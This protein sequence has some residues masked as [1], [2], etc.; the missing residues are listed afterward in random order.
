[1]PDI[2]VAK[3]HPAR[4]YD[5]YIGGKNHFAADRAVADKALAAWPAGRT[6]LRENRGFLGRAVRFL[7][8]EAGIRQFLDIG[9]GLPTTSNVHE[10]AQ[11]VAPS[12]RVVYVD[13]DSMVLAH[14]RALLASAPEGRTAYIQADLRV[15][16][17]ILASPVVRS[18]L[19]FSQPIALMLVAVLHF[20][21]DDDKPHEVVGT[22]LDALPPGS[23]L[24]ASHMTFEHE[25][26]V[27][28]GQQIYREAGLPMQM[29]D[30]D[31]FARL[32]FPGLEMAPPGVVLVSEWR[33]A[34]TG[35]RPGP[36]EVS[37]YG[38]VARKLLFPARG[39]PARA[40]MVSMSLTRA[41]WVGASGVTLRVVTP[42]SLN[43]ARRSAT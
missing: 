24:A 30:A 3:P 4:M 18:V 19:D 38:G 8:E 41:W 21:N 5:Y 25:P 26:G 34:A 13:N 9:S 31:E 36:A 27:A 7:A 2:D 11:A 12:S 20:L 28:T 1:M 17:E 23:Y 29:R 43:A 42:D 16:A 10:V 22:L 40:A 37:C 15:P 33:R 35:P 39:Y 32:A 14:A 6:G